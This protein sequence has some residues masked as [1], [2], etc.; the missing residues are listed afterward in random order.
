MTKRICMENRPCVTVCNGVRHLGPRRRRR[1]QSA[2]DCGAAV[3]SDAIGAACLRRRAL[4]RRE[5]APDRGCDRPCRVSTC[6]AGCAAR[7]AALAPAA[8]A[9]DLQDRAGRAARRPSDTPAARRRRSGRSSAPTRSNMTARPT[10]SP[11]PATCGCSAQG[12]RLRADKV[13]WNRKTGQVVATGNIAVTNPEG[14][15]AYGDRIELTDSLKDGVVENMLVVL[16][17]GGRL[18]ARARR[19]RRE[20]RHR[21]SS[22]AAYTP[23]AVTDRDG[24]P[25]E[26]SWK[27]T[28]VRVI[29]RPGNA[30]ASVTRARAFQLFGLPTL[31]LPAFSPPDRRRQRQRPAGARHPLRAAS[32]GSRSPLPYYLQPRAQSRPDGHAARLHRRAADAAGANIA[33]STEHRRVPGH[34]LWHL[35]PPQRRPRVTATPATTEHGVSR[36]SRRASAASSSIPN[37]SVSG[38][39]RLTHRPHLPAPLRHLARRPAA[40]DARGRADR[41]RQLFLDRRLGGADAAR[42]R[43][44]RACSRSRCPRSTIA[45]AS[46][47]PLLGGRVELQLNTLAIGRTD[48]QDTQRA[49]A[50]ARWDLRRLTAWGQEVTLTAYAPR[51]RLQHRR[52]AARPRSPSYRG[53]E[54]WHG[55]GDRRA[56]RST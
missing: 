49:F 5:C 14:D 4:A 22:S 8:A 33:R 46:T 27:I 25:K 45:A 36:L 31:P 7:A 17:Q 56:A 54:G 23:C 26:P 11:P 13:V 6:L 21:R 24:C 37:W 3:R 41:R 10:S 19:A 12:D 44:A 20:R 39:L 42:R 28:A 16:E 18:A 2:R 32:T 35:Q 9:Q 38:S 50:S 34:R 29:Y 48:G 47:T 53:D 55:R 43:R 51:R 30:S 40:L 15:I 52:D 1:R